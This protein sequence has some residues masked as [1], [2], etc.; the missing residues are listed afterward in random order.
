IYN[1]SLSL[2]QNRATV[3][4]RRPVK[5]FQAI[6]R[7]M[8]GLNSSYHSLQVSLDKRYSRGFTVSTS[9]TWSRS[10]DYVST[11]GFGGSFGINNPFDFFFSRGIA[12]T[13]R[14]HRFV[15]SFVAD[16][17][18]LRRGSTISAI[19]G[20]W[21]LSGIVLLQAG[22]PFTV[23]SSNNSMAGAGASRADLV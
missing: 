18:R 19:L 4:E 16:L 2:A 15:T 21:R 6:M 8:H 1:T 13:S 11:A 23:G 22:R 5:D 14:D 12:N 17:P 7:W 3:N 10:L 9:Y 20:Q